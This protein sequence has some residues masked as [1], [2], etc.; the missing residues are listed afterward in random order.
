M[1]LQH[2]SLLVRDLE[3]SKVFYRDFLGMSEI[4]RARAFA[5]G[6]WMSSGEAEI[7]LIQAKET[8][9]AA[10]F[11]LDDEGGKIGLAT[12]IAFEVADLTDLL[13][14][15]ATLDI[16]IVGGPIQRDDGVTQYYFHDPDR[17]LIELFGWMDSAETSTKN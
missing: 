14:R 3:K 7:H 1:K 2:C 12:H 15:A 11:H 6:A 16:P 13:G 5:K 9:A 10:G 4:P 8:T 17:Y